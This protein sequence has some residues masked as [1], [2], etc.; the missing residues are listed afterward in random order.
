MISLCSKIVSYFK[1]TQ[2]NITGNL[3]PSY[4]ARSLVCEADLLLTPPHPPF[5][6]HGLE[7]VFDEVSKGWRAMSH[8]LV[9]TFSLLLDVQSP[10]NCFLLPHVSCHL[11]FSGRRQHPI[12]VSASCTEA[13]ICRVH[14]FKDPSRYL[15]Y[16]LGTLFRSL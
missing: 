14:F 15:A 1:R 6:L 2:R 13:E 9:L 11:V 7:T 10:G 5:S 8:L 12:C 4:L 3:A 16:W